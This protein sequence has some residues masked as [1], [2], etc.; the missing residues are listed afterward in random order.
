[1]LVESDHIIVGTAGHIDH[2]KTALIKALTGVDTDTL[3]EE[4]RR[5]ITI[6]LGFAFLETPDFDKQI[7]FIDVPGHEK[8]IK[9]MVAGASNIDAV[10]FVIAADEGVEV[11]TLEHLDI[12]QLL[13]IENGI[14]ALAKA[15][16][17][18]DVHIAAV[19]E[20]VR[21]VVAGTF[22]ENAPIIP[23]SSVTKEGV[24]E[25]KAALV[26]AARGVRE[27]RDTGVFRMPVDRAFTMQGFGTV[28]AGTILSGQVNVGDKLEILPDG[29]TARVRGI[30][31]HAKS[32]QESHIGIRTAI[33]LVDVKKEQLR[34]GQSA[35]APGSATPTSRLD[36]QLHLLRGVGEEVKNRMR[37]RLHVNADEVMAR[38]V[39]PDRDKMAQGETAVVQFVLES[40]TVALPRDRF[41]IRTF[42]SLATLGGGT[43]V[44][45]QPKAH[46]RFDESTMHALERVASGIAGAV[47]QAFVKSGAVPLSVADVA[48]QLGETESEVATAARELLDGGRLVRIVPK[49]S[50]DEV[51]VARGKFISSQTSSMLT[52]RLLGLLNAYYAANPYRVYMP[53]PDLQS[54]FLK[55]AD[56]QVYDALIGNL[57]SQEI[58]RAVGARVG[59]VG[60][61]P[62]WKPGE[63]E[64]AAKIESIYE[65]T[66]YSSPSEEDLR[67]ELRIAPDVFANI[68]TALMD[69]RRLVRLGERVTYHHKCLRS[70]RDIV[71][72]AI[73]ESGGIT[74]A[75]LRDKLDVTRKYAIAVLEYLDTAQVTR[76]LGDKRVLR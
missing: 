33:N 23:V 1:M 24:N 67:Q 63:R 58:L 34:R 32:V 37:V 40:P 20:N 42:S 39:L 72:G 41:V 64:L 35:V 9:T 7:I 8:L 30:Q 61:Q 22:L 55:L 31:V 48:G 51:D 28:I 44:D 65:T 66:G 25:V 74:A 18:D 50:E 26:D 21:S 62:D 6:E 68:I 13:G 52:E 45:A 5:G 12:L 29:L 76:R 53:S 4:K 56:K 19:T 15:D 16:M 46:K 36:G 60:K 47:E 2:G 14:I 17:V 57:C 73:R 70:A 11:Q 10:L 69:M 38:V 3:A 59:L 71:V 27:R 54:R 49:G 43:I 75:E